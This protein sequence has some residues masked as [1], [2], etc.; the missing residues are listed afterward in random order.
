LTIFF[1][2]VCSLIIDTCWS[3]GIL[4]FTVNSKRFYPSS[5]WKS[6]NPPLR[7]GRKSYGQS[8]YDNV[9]IYV[10]CNTVGRVEYQP[11]AV[12]GLFLCSFDSLVN[13][14]PQKQFIT[15]LSIDAFLETPD[16]WLIISTWGSWEDNFSVAGRMQ[17]PCLCSKRQPEIAHPPHFPVMEI[18]YNN[19]YIMNRVARVES[20]LCQ[21]EVRVTSFRR[22][23]QFAKDW[24]FVVLIAT[25]V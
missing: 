15:A 21:G 18:V 17:A 9:S 11:M 22:G 24:N 8:E 16:A 20:R 3:I 1:C 14:E 10:L 23:M 13:L 4:P 12:G 19:T 7:N 25:N 5:S 6:G 2:H